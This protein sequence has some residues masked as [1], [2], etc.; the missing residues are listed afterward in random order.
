MRSG[1]AALTAL[2]TV[3][4]SAGSAFADGGGVTPGTPTP[5]AD[6]GWVRA[7]SAGISMAARVNA[8][9]GSVHPVTGAVPGGNRVVTLDARPQGGSWKEVA[10]G[11]SARSGK[12]SLGWK[13]NAFGHVD[14]RVRAAGIVGAP[15]G[16]VTAYRSSRA[17]IFGGPGEYQASACGPAIAKGTLGVANRTLPCGTLVQVAFGNRSMV[18]PVID[19]GPYRHGFNWDVTFAA[20]T[21]LAMPGTSTIGYLV[22]GKDGI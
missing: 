22:V 5:G 21:T 1:L 7:H 9:G 20:A 14:V 3:A 6:A 2:L 13:V 12:Y 17:T 19:R 4:L 10:R 16:T 8:F 15:S 18:L 11:R